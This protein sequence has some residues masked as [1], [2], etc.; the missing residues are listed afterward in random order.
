LVK[1]VAERVEKELVGMEFHGP[2][3]EVLWLENP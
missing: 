1:V 2:E 3:S